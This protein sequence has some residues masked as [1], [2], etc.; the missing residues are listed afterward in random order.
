VIE[1]KLLV[2]EKFPD[3]LLADLDRREAALWL[4]DLPTNQAAREQL[5]S[6]L[7]LPWRMA[8]VEPPDP[9]L[10]KALEGLANATDPLTRKRG[11]LQIVDGDPSRIEL[12]PRCLPIYLLSGRQGGPQDDFQSRL[13]RMTMLEELRRSGVRQVLIVSGGDAP[14]PPELKDL[15]SSGFRSFLTFATDSPDG[16]AVL[17]A[18][19]SAVG[20]PG[21]VSLLRLSPTRVITTILRRYVETYPEERVVI[22]IRNRSGTFRKLDITQI[23]EPERPLLGQYSLIEEKHLS[24]I[25]PEQLSEEEF[26][27]FFQNP[28][29]SWRPYA[30]GL[31]WERDPRAERQLGNVMK[32]IDE[33]GP[34][35][36]R[37]A[38]VSAEP[39]AG[40]TTFVRMLAWEYAREGYP[41]LVAEQFPFVPD[42]LLI[43][44]FLNRV[45]LEYEAPEDL[46]SSPGASV[47]THRTETPER[48]GGAR[49]YEVPWIIVFD[50]VHWQHRDGELRRFR[51]ELVKQGRPVCLLVVSGPIREMSYFDKS[52][53]TQIGELNHVLDQAE[54]LG[55]GRHLNQFLRLYGKAREERQWER[56]YQEHTVRYL[57][58]MAAFWVTLSFWIQGQYDISESIQEWIYRSFREQADEG[59]MQDAILEIAA[60]SSE[61][62]PL[63]EALLPTSRGAWPVSHLLEDR[64]SH[65]GAIGLVRIAPARERYWALIHDILGRLLINALFYDFPTRMKMGFGEAK[66]PEHLRFLLL[67]RV[68]L[69]HELG[70]RAYREFGD[71]FATSIFKIDPDH[72]HAN[73]APFWREVLAT[74][75]AMAR[76]LRDGSRV[77]RH[78]TA[79]SRRRIAK[80]NEA[81]Y[82]VTIDDKVALLNKAIEDIRYALQSID[83]APGSEPNLNLYNSLAHAYHDLADLEEARGSAP[84]AV[85]ELRDLAKEVTRRAYEESPTNSFVIET[86]V[87]DLLANARTIQGSAIEYCV[88]ALGILF[89]A[90]SSNEESYRRAQLGDL[91]DKALVILF[92]HAPP[93]ADA[94][95][96]NSAIDVLTRAWI[97]LAEGVDYQSGTALSDLP[98]QNRVRAIDALAHPA[99]RG[100]MQVIRLY[101]E[102]ICISF[103]HDFRRQLEYLQQLQSTDYR[104]TP[105]LRLEYGILLYQ[106]NRSVEGDQVFRE[107]RR[108]WR[109]SEQFVQ[110]PL[111]LRWLRDVDSEAIKSVQAIIG[112][113]RGVRAMARVSEFRNLMVPFRPEEFGLRVVRPG[114]RFVAH[115]SFGHNGPFLRPVTARAT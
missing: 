70:E 104:T 95:E 5:P 23:D 33:G 107:L 60:V 17:E 48:S 102:L 61:R 53:F 15:W 58:G 85:S 43:A 52:V 109:E 59:L 2:I 113:D 63:P 32:R 108:I 74:L 3:S 101:Y 26:V 93:Y 39:G 103:P 22:R 83:Y 50:Q 55:L 72:G 99:G 29:T 110:V 62:L 65:L 57:E 49:R 105:Q 96:P 87:R 24:P 8:F 14:L 92:K 16:R 7:G 20:E 34:E 115:V 18:W 46:T 56:F 45:R 97:I 25:T 6:F 94:T 76:P 84:E 68:A 111:R 28:E 30:A 9:S 1:P 11:F 114:I 89:S 73:F 40:A 21:R 80:L 91:A 36:N 86:Y 47:G 27:S 13:R 75:D 4:R 42:G 35:E 69:K 77:F 41:V 10:V 71:D 44:N 67:R 66:D 82:G 19:V 112:S 78:H 31:P 79:I 38:Y 54:T 51:N 98:E 37:I 100:N 88:E 90:I 12:P 106:N 64:R 81:I